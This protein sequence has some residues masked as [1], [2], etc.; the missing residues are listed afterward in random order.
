MAS[1]ET[2][3]KT[4]M[5]SAVKNKLLGRPKLLTVCWAVFGLSV[6]GLFTWTIVVN[7]PLGGEPVAIVE[8][9]AKSKPSVAENTDKL[10]MRTSMRPEDAPSV[11]RPEVAPETNV[12]TA[13]HDVLMSPEP[14][15]VASH[16]LPRA[17]AKGLTEKIKLGVLPRIGDD[18]RRPSQI[19]AR[20]L[21]RDA[22][23][24]PSPVRIAIFV[25]GMGLSAT[26]TQSAI[27]I[28]ST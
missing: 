3:P 9:G 27:D 1:D 14:E 20:K 15:A 5:L 6:A 18:G 28:L 23:A 26:G 17:P 21:D 24:S 7:D 22:T 10:G 16:G 11:S 12:A 4:N 2:E 8:L 19:Y 25:G 13:E